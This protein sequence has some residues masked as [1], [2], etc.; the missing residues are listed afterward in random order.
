MTVTR[1]N[2]VDDV[3]IRH[4]FL[5]IHGL[6]P[7]DFD[8]AFRIKLSVHLLKIFNDIRSHKARSAGIWLS[9]SFQLP[10]LRTQLLA[11]ALI[12][13]GEVV[14]R[15]IDYYKRSMTSISKRLAEIFFKPFVLHFLS[16][17]S[18]IV[19]RSLGR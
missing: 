2:L 19:T 16:E 10:G 5:N 8:R 9:V 15:V 13:Q 1:G 17:V 7:K 3:L 18:I 11:Q 12:R 6:L 14:R 4:I